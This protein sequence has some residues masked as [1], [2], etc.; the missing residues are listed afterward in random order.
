MTV[1]E[2]I[3]AGGVDALARAAAERAVAEVCAEWVLILERWLEQEWANPETDLLLLAYLSGEIN[4]LRRRM[5]PSPERK[6]AQTRERVR[7]WRARK[8][9][10]ISSCCP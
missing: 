9:A 7:R 5:P 1:D 6:R 3:R 8:L 2:L 4:R 10:K